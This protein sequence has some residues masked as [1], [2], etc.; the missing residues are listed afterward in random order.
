MSQP[1]AVA[2]GSLLN[3]AT[4]YLSRRAE[5]HTARVAGERA[6]AIFEAAY[7]SDHAEVARP[8]ANLGIVV[9]QLGK[10]EAARAALERALAIFEAAYGPDHPQVA[11]TLTNLG[12]VLRELGELD[13]A[14]AVQERALAISEAASPGDS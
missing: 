2:A 4:E 1:A 14:Q 3:W 12:I 7:G 13:A 9:R 8:L 5:L 6:V 11:V 10:L